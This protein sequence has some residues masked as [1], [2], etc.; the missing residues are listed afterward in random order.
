MENMCFGKGG[1]MSRVMHGIFG[2]FLSL[3]ALL[4]FQAPVCGDSGLLG[5]G[6]EALGQGG[7]ATTTIEGPSALYWNPAGVIGNEGSRLLLSFGLLQRP[8]LSE[9]A[10]GNTERYLVG[11]S[12]IHPPRGT[13]EAY[14]V[15]FA[16]QKPYPRIEYREERTFLDAGGQ[17]QL[18]Q[19]GLS[20]DYGEI[21]AGA[22]YYLL[23]WGSLGC[24]WDLRAGFAAGVGYSHNTCR[25][26]VTTGSGSTG[27][28]T[29]ENVRESAVAPLGAGL[30]LDCRPGGPVDVS[31]GVSY[32]GRRFLAG[33]RILAFGEGGLELFSKDVLPLFP[34]DEFRLG[35]SA[36]ILGTFTMSAGADWMF[37]RTPDWFRSAFPRRQMN[38][39][40]GLEYRQPVGFPLEALAFRV[41]VSRS[42]V[43]AHRAPD[44]FTVD[45]TGLYGG[46][47]VVLE[48]QVTLDVFCSYHL[49][50]DGAMENHILA[51][52]SLGRT[53]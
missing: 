34:S 30:I 2:V 9:S 53:F 47:G 24:R 39:R 52:A 32:R 22:S 27:L 13:F 31:A 42:F 44:P 8:D 10:Y 20:S 19:V 1:C 41:G 3:L 11:T 17:E 12:L 36:E 25:G 28:D 29:D 48:G 46:I 4:L 45:A 26:S 38:L 16:V 6:A 5:V 23:S 33:D 50:S 18:L 7:A 43:H 51:G 21:I 40:G 14:G 35:V 49:P 15:F 37:V